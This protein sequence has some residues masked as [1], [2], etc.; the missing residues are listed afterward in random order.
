MTN[1]SRFDSN[2]HLRG[3]THAYNTLGRHISF[4][5][6][7]YFEVGSFSALKTLL[8]IKHKVEKAGADFKDVG[9]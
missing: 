6:L 7:L 8:Q 2:L 1:N 9:D 4:N 5:L 3:L